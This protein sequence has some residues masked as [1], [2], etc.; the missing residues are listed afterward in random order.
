MIIFGPVRTTAQNIVRGTAEV[1]RNGSPDPVEKIGR[2]AEFRNVARPNRRH[3]RR[4]WH[5]RASRIFRKFVE[6]GGLFI[7]VGGNASLPIDFGITSRRVDPGRKAICRRADRYSTRSSPTAKARS[8]TAMTKNWR[9]I[10]IRRRCF[11]SAAVGGFGG[12]AQPAGR[13]SRTR[14]RGRSRRHSGPPAGSIPA[15]PMPTPD[16]AQHPAAC[17]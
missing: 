9:S 5:Y 6:A 8:H 14:H 4:A 17:T 12:P 11:R 2:Y 10:L 13:P 3:S 15:A 16:P 1:Q 7:T